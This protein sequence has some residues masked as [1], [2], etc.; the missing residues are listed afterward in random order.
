MVEKVVENWLKAGHTSKSKEKQRIFGAF[1]L[2][3]LNMVV[4]IPNMG[5]CCYKICDLS[6]YKTKNQWL[7]FNWGTIKGTK[8]VHRSQN[9]G[10]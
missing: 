3:L 10:S 5:I 8:E 6:S 7:G 9:F 1:D 2:I 4:I